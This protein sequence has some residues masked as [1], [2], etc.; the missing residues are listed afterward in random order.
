LLKDIFPG[1][2]SSWPL[3][4]AF[5]RPDRAVFA[6]YEPEH[7]SEL[8]I[9]DFTEEGTQ[10]A[11]D[12]YPGP[13]NGVGIAITTPAAEGQTVYFYAN[14]GIHGAELWRFKPDF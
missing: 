8:W 4:F 6:A 12:I 2:G 1:A 5:P 10:L 9:S 7:G 13:R 3:H 14:E 11:A